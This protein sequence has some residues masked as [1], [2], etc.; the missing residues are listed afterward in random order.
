LEICKIFVIVLPGEPIELL[1]GMSFGP[2]FGTIIIYAGVVITTIFIYK[3]VQKYGRDLVKDVVSEEKLEKIEKKMNENTAKY[4]NIL[5][6][7]Y[8]LP[9][10]P[11]DILT[12]IGSL[13]PISF[14]KFLIVTLLARFPAII[15]STIVGDSI[16][17]GDIKTII[18]AYGT[19]YVISI[20]IASIYNKKSK[21]KKDIKEGLN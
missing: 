6:V 4:E 1:A 9:I 14:R 19:T 5:F 10:V 3:A 7:L 8:F 11:K 15:S 17:D 2:I 16:L 18:L 20:L 12:Y 21:N 13:L